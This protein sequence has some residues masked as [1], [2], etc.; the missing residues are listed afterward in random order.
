[1]P[2]SEGML[3]AIVCLGFCFALSL[4]PVSLS[5]SR[6]ARWQAERKN[7]MQEAATVVIPA[8]RMSRPLLRLLGHT[9]QNQSRYAA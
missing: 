6:L 5:D 2:K 4:V 9:G 3:Q 7:T 8:A 1:M